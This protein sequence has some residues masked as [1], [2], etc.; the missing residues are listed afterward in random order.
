MPM[1][2]FVPLPPGFYRRGA[3]VVAPKLL[4]HWLVTNGPSGLCGGRMVEVEAYLCDDPASHSF[5]GRT[6]RNASMFAAPGSAYVY[7]IYG[8]HLCLN[9]ACGPEGVGEAVL[10]RAITAEW[11]IAKMAGRRVLPAPE[12]SL[13]KRLPLTSGP[14]KL[15]QA[16]GVTRTM[17]GVSLCRADSPVFIAKAPDARA[18]VRRHGGIAR[19]PRIGISSAKDAPLRFWLRDSPFVSRTRRSMAS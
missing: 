16:L 3:A 12:D 7:F 18:F 11:G 17:D 15:A 9:A 2:N 5:R 10:I 6:A 8:M 14:A 4:G 13:P 1:M 19:G